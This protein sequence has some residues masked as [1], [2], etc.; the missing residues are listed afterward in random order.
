MSKAMSYRACTIYLRP[1]FMWRRYLEIRP[2]WHVLRASTKVYMDRNTDEIKWIEC[3]QSGDNGA[4]GVLP[5][6]VCLFVAQVSPQRTPPTRQDVAIRAIL[7]SGC[8]I[9]QVIPWRACTTNCPAITT[10]IWR[11][12]CPTTPSS[13]AGFTTY[14]PCICELADDNAFH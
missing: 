7:A 3:L 5:T 10:T 11:H 1:P 12:C 9:P 6:N 8:H 2:S 4:S 13:S 14:T